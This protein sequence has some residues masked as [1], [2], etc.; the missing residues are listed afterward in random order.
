MSESQTDPDTRQV[1]P[2]RDRPAINAIWDGHDEWW[3]FSEAETPIE[4]GRYLLADD[5]TVCDV[6]R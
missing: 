3:I 1:P 5:A 4:D 2:R 6:H